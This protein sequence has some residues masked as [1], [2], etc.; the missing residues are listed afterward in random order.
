MRFISLFLMCHIHDFL[1]HQPLGKHQCVILYIMRSELCGS[2][3][4][5]KKGGDRGWREKE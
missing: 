1:P 4:A 3:E 2:R 5:E